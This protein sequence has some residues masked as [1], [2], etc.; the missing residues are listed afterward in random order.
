VPILIFDE[1]LA[2]PRR[3]QALSE[4]GIE[5]RTISDFGAAGRP[6]PEVVRRVA[7]DLGTGFVL[8]TMD[9][10][11]VEHHEGFEWRATRLHG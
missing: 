5:V 10:N 9:V 8:V 4:R 7:R 1:Q 11:I 2:S 6:D 3:V